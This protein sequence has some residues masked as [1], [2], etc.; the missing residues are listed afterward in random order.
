M[1]LVT[2]NYD[3]P[4]TS[5]EKV[6]AE[7]EHS[8][9]GIQT[10]G[11]FNLCDGHADYLITSCGSDQIKTKA[12]KKICQTLADGSI[13]MY[14]E[15]EFDLPARI[16]ISDHH[17]EDCIC[18]RDLSG[19][20]V[21]IMMMFS[22]CVQAAEGLHFGVVPY[23]SRPAL[24]IVSGMVGAGGNAGA[25]LTLWSIFKNDDVAR[26]DEGFVVLGI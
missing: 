24:G 23:V 17:G 13:K 11:L 2:I 18:N 12:I 8:E 15:G 16:M 3:A 1:G 9:F 14:G 4:S 5:S 10:E 21:L 20:V 19:L 25:V 26:T 22:C 6:V 7:F